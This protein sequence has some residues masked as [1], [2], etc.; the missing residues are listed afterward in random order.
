MKSLFTFFTKYGQ[1]GAL[2]LG[3]IFVAIVFFSIFSGL[4]GAGYET[5]TDLVQILQ[6]ENNTQDFN[7]FNPTAVIPVILIG[8][9]FFL[10][11]FFLLTDIIR[12]PKGSMKLLIGL[13]IVGVLMFVFYSTSVSETSGSIFE[14]MQEFDVSENASKLISGGIKTS[15]LLAVLSFAGIVLMEIW[16]LFK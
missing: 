16:N 2:L 4:K 14:K 1:G 5:S 13:F 7:F 3:L 9:G 12:D 11:A 6:S 8:F 10:I 15:V